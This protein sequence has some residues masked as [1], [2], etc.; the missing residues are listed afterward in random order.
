MES[1]GAS[2]A[3]PS[4]ANLCK[5]QSSLPVSLL[6]VCLVVRSVVVAEV[7]SGR[8]ARSLAQMRTVLGVK[9][10]NEGLQVAAFLRNHQ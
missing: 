2:A 3:L 10:R 8:R 7:A 9:I 6:S 1:S 4:D 5:T